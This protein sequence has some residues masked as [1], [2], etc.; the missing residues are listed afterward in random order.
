MAWLDQRR[1]LRPPHGTGIS[2]GGAVLGAFIAHPSARTVAE[3]AVLAAMA[4][5]FL[6]GGRAAR[7]CSTPADSTHRALPVK[8]GGA[9]RVLRE[10]HGRSSAS[11][12]RYLRSLRS[13]WAAALRLDSRRLHYRW[14]LDLSG[15]HSFIQPGRQSH[16]RAERL[17]LANGGGR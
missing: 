7:A 4:R 1:R 5:I 13:T 6:V 11:T 15:V 9:F 10:V 17:P 12:G 3:K 14:S 16:V 8:A 2:L